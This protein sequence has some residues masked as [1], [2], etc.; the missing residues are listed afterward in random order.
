MRTSQ[1]VRPWLVCLGGAVMLFSVMGLGSNVY[2]VY[3]PYIIA[4]NGFTNTQAAWIITTRSLFIVLG[5]LTASGVCL[6]LGIRRACTGA[7]LLLAL[8]RFLFGAATSLP[9]YLGAAAITGL[10]YG[11]GGMIPLSLLI[12]N[13]FRDRNAFALGLASA[14]SGLATIVLP[15]PLTWLIQRWGLTAACWCE[16]AFVLLLALLVLLLVRDTPAQLGLHPYCQTPDQTAAPKP[17]V[18]PAP[19]GMSPLYW[20]LFLTAVFLTGAPTAIGMTNVGVL[21]RTEGFDPGTVAALVSCVGLSL[22]GG[23]LLYGELADRLGG[24]LASYLLY[25]LSLLSYVLLCMAPNG[26]RL[27]AFAG[28]IAFGLGLPLSNVSFSIW[29][30]DFLGDAGFAKGLKWSQSLYALGI[31]VFGPVPGWLADRTG[32]YVASYALFGGMMALSFLFI[33]LVYR[34]TKSGGP[35]A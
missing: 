28:V 5:M 35:P 30:R 34:R 4:Q 22:M 24:R 16:G 17:A 31:V 25:A 2:S 6:R 1:S 27:A 29:A 7:M 10:A 13:W 14:G 3:Q 15:A 32:S 9:A 11:W 21:Y 20:G 19:A 8:S 33:I 18:R 26:S 23:K 12:N